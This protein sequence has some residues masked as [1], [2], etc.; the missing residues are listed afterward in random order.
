MLEAAL[1]LPAQAGDSLLGLGQVPQQASS[2]TGSEPPRQLPAGPRQFAGRAAELAMLTRLIGAA[3]ERGDPLPVI[4]IVGGAGVGKTAL[5][6]RWAHQNKGAFAGGQLYADLRNDGNAPSPAASLRFLR[7]FIGALRPAWD[8]AGNADLDTLASTYR[9]LVAERRLLVVLDNARDAAQV[10]PLLPGNPDCLVLVT[11]RFQLTGL[12]AADGAQLLTLEVMTTSESRA[13]L[14]ARLGTERIAA[15]PRAVAEL[16]TLCGGLPLALSIAAARVLARPKF[17]LAELVTD[18][19][20]SGQLDALDT[21]EAATAIRSVFSSSH[22]RLS[23]RP[24]RCSACSACIPDLASPSVPRPASA[25]CRCL[26][27][28]PRWPN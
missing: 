10:R 14:T 27:R 9:T 26:R 16:I 19:R 25:G 6:L 12:A 13:F 5:A 17:A 20:A 7:R 23:S 22:D 3:E 8:A 4:A 28:T 1:E 18:L 11:S 24:P 15:E 2:V 21:G